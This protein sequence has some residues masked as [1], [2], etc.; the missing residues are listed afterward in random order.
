MIVGIVCVC[1]NVG[2]DK[3][4]FLDKLM[5]DRTP[6]FFWKVATVEKSMIEFF[7]LKI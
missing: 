7:L 5:R 1:I 3:N 6:V 4:A 2:N